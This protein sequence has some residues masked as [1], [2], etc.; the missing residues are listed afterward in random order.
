MLHLAA[1]SGA[2]PAL[3]TSLL[4]T[5]GAAQRATERFDGLYPLHMALLCGA[6]LGSVEV[7]LRRF[8]W[9]LRE[10]SDKG[11]TPLACAVLGGCGPDVLWHLTEAESR[12]GGG[13]GGGGSSSSSSSGSGSAL[14]KTALSRGSL[15]LTP[16]MLALQAGAALDVV[17]ALVSAWPEG[18]R[19]Q[20]R[21]LGGAGGPEGAPA[22]AAAAAAATYPLHFAAAYCPAAVPLLVERHPEAAAVVGGAG[23]PG[24]LAGTPLKLLLRSGKATPSAVGALAR[25]APGEAALREVLMLAFQAKCSPEC[26]MALTRAS[27]VVVL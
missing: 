2:P 25:A 6:P 10:E 9:A 24:L 26:I 16:L 13:G 19:A 5:A 14:Q 12:A 8:P 1:R 21:F 23:V 7:L 18:A 3:L 4:D 11:L 20:L 27:P 15:L 22:A 17:A